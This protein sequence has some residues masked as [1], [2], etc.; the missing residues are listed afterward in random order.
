MQMVGI[1][2]LDQAHPGLL[3]TAELDPFVVRSDGHPYAKKIVRRQPQAK[4]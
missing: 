3:N 2:S 4:L 1:A